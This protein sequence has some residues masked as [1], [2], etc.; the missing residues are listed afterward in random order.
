MKA[1]I[2]KLV[3]GASNAGDLAIEGM[4]SRVATPM[5]AIAISCVGRRLV[6]GERIEDETE[7]LQDVLPRGTEI[8]G[9]YSYGELSPQGTNTCELHNQTMTVTLIQE[10]A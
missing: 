6:L 10:T 3:S 8:V 9:F 7:S 2:S 4:P 5:L 1:N